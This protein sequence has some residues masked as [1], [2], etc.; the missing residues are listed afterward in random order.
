[1]KKFTYLLSYY[2]LSHIRSM[3]ILHRSRRRCIVNRSRS[4]VNR[5]RSMYWSIVHGSR[6]MMDR[7]SLVPLLHT[8]LPWEQDRSL[9]T[10]GV[11]QL[12]GALLQGLGL[13]GCE[14]KLE[15]FLLL[16]NMRHSK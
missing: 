5:C 8:D 1:M 4:I 13:L 12:R 7:S 15:A 9:L 10:L 2:H 16:Q 3:C 6:S 11:P 14:G